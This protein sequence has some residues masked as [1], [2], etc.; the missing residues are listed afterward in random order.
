[1]T[2]IPEAFELA[3][4]HHRDG[5]LQEA[6][7]I[8]RQ[9]LAT[10]P[11]HAQSLHMLGVLAHRAGRADLAVQYLQSALAIEPAAALFHNSLGEVL[12]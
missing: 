11:R 2:T 4:A 7:T 9:I 5:R 6:E 10:E 12:R 3:V 8:Y 1:M